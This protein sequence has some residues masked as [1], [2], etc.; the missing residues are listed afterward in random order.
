MTIQIFYL[1]NFIY[2]DLISL[3]QSLFIRKYKNLQ[4]PESFNN[5]YPNV[6]DIPENR[7]TRHDD[8]NL[9]YQQPIKNNTFS[10]LQ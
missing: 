2:H 6:G 5:I 8:F 4:L 10:L 9:T 3:N 1:K 7:R